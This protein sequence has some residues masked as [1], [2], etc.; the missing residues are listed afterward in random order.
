VVRPRSFLFLFVTAISSILSGCATSAS[1]EPQRPLPYDLEHPS[2]IIQLPDSLRE[3]SDISADNPGDPH[4]I[5]CVQDELGIVFAFHLLTK[6]ITRKITFGDVGDYEGIASSGHTL[7]VLR[8]DGEIFNASDSIY[9]EVPLGKTFTSN[10]PAGDNEGLCWEPNT[11]RFLIGCKSNLRGDYS[12]DKRGIFAFMPPVASPE[13]VFLFD[14]GMI[15]QTEMARRLPGK[16][17]HIQMRISAIAVHPLTDELYVLSAEDH[18]L[19]LFSL[20]NTLLDIRYLD[21]DLF[22]KPEGITFLHD[23]EMIISNEGVKA[24]ATLLRFTYLQD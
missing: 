23:G 7:L 18:L 21:P 3:I 4:S 15:R 10:V 16:P 22:P 2:E 14:L 9:P 13:P 19:F 17:V 8:S 6:K 20:Q 24:P 12:K 11:E 1:G 5:F